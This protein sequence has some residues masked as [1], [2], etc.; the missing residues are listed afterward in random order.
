ME[1]PKALSSVIIIGEILRG[2][3]MISRGGQCP[4]M[5]P[6]G[7]GLPK[8]SPPFCLGGKR[9]YAIV[10]LGRAVCGFISPR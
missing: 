10:R 5:P 9:L 8:A 6:G 1:R 7:T 3:K 2:G 4:S